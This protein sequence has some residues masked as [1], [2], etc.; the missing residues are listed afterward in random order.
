VVLDPLV[1][2]APRP[3]CDV[4]RNA[5]ALDRPRSA[6]TAHLP[7]PLGVTCGAQGVAYI[8]H[9]A[10]HK[11]QVT[12]VAAAWAQPPQW[13]RENAR[14]GLTESQHYRLVLDGYLI[15]EAHCVAGRWFLGRIID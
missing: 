3:F 9:H 11:R 15:V 4:E 12:H 2:A 14:T 6:L 8:A 5:T 10:G 13:W 7:A 1:A